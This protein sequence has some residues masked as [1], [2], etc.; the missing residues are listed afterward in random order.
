M[1]GRIP[2]E[3][4]DRVRRHFDI[5]DVVQ[6]YVQLKKSGRNYF[7]LCP[8]HSE[9]TPSFSV[10]P[11]KQI[12][13]CF[14][15]GAGGDIIKFVMEI[16]Q[17][18]FIEAV[19]HLAEQA[20]I[21]IPE[22]GPVSDGREEEERRQMREALKLASKL[23]HHLLVHTEYGRHAREYLKQ[24]QVSMETVEEFQL[25]FAP[26][27]N[28]FLL[29]F[30][31][32]RGFKEEVLEKA[33]LIATRDSPAQKKYYDRFRNRIMFPI[34]DSQGGVIAFGGRII[35]DGHP[36]YLNSPETPLFHKGNH[37][38]NLHRARSHIR[39]EQQAVLF[40]GYMDVIAAWQAGIRTGIATLG[41]SFTD[42]QARVI[43]RNAETVIICYDADSAGQSAALRGLEI[44][45]NHD[46]T[47]KVAQMPVGMDPDDYIRRHGGDA[48]KEEILAGSLSLTSFKLE[49]LKKSF[50]LRD[51]DE[52]I[53][54]LAKAVDVISDLP[55]A[56]EQDHYLRRLAEEFHLSLDSLK[57]ELRKR[58]ALKK[59]E[60]GR[61]KGESKWNN[62]Y[63]RE[64]GKQ[65]IGG[66]RLLSVT[67]RSEMLLVAHMMRDKSITEWVK[68]VLGADFHTEIYAAL[69]AYLYAYYEQGNP[70]DVGRFI[71]HLP[72]QALIQKASE[73]AMLD[74]PDEV[75]QEALNDYV[76]HI[77]NYPL[78]KE[79][80]EKERLVEQLSRADEPVKAAQLSLEIT[81]LRKQL[82]L[83]MN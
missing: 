21:H 43:R 20:G 13:H 52:R 42:D 28:Q 11:E 70:E 36:K 17:Y 3:I 56:I 29:S 49:S 1:G 27:S 54:Y 78:L 71:G 48:F 26:P 64:T 40:E 47:V 18:T 59:R 34:H 41:T 44:L 57:E 37:L 67:E 10:S 5:L 83:R 68:R 61:D 32:Q 74:L 7:G 69:A 50:N 58:K 72:D 53:K 23:Y 14:G 76:R 8:F 60:A 4:I 30:L 75:S 22:T 63:Y 39:K 9:R 65:M 33:G 35:G 6:Q 38:F 45:R 77:R 16:E 51:E 2:D 12:F 73:L 15:C 46:C 62:G 82:Q 81:E 55:L 24:R 66:S 79:I 19:R 31:K 80:E 25:G